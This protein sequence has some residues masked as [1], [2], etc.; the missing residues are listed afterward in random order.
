MRTVKESKKF[1]R[2][3]CPLIINLK[4]KDKIRTNGI[5]ERRVL[6]VSK[7]RGSNPGRTSRPKT[8]RPTPPITKAE[9]NNKSLIGCLIIGVTDPRFAPATKGPIKNE[10]I[11]RNK[12]AG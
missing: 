2:L 6:I 4:T 7:W 10:I 1:L 11:P 8:P 5:K 3:V 9:N 12:K